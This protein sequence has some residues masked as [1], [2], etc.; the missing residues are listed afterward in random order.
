MMLLLQVPLLCHPRCAG[1]PVESRRNLAAKRAR[2]GRAFASCQGASCDDACRRGGRGVP[3][4]ASRLSSGLLDP[5]RTF[6]VAVPCRIHTNLNDRYR[7][8]PSPL[9]AL[10]W[11]RVV[12]DEAHMVESTTQ[13]TAK[14]ALKIPARHR[15]CMSVSALQHELFFALS[16]GV[17]YLPGV[18]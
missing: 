1:V 5:C 6:C 16:R 12:V 10:E 13:E 18:P 17:R 14:M 4:V 15:Y 2:T 9:P 3:G 8:I 7:V 11:W